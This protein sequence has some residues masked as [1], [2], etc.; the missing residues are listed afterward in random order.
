ML[1]RELDIH[2]FR[3]TLQAY[4]LPISCFTLA[5]FVVVGRIDED[6]LIAGAVASP[7]IA[8]GVL[9]GAWLRNHIEA[10]LFRRLVVGL[11]V[12]MRF[13]SSALRSSKPFDST[14]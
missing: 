11:L 14:P 3:A 2:R 4:F 1:G 8:G 6:V 10:D 9:V 12:V 7:A 13:W 5:L